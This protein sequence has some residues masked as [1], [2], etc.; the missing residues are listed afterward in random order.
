MSG[1]ELI[2]HNTQKSMK[3]TK[4]LLVVSTLGFA[5]P[6][7]QAELSGSIALDY[8]SHF[9]SYGADVWG[10][11][12]D[13]DDA[14]FNPSLALEYAYSDSIT[15][16]G[17][18]WFDIN[19][20]PGGGFQVQETDFWL[21]LTYGF[22]W[23]SFDVTWQNWQYAGTSEEILDFTLS[24]DTILSPSLTLH[25]RIGEGASGGDEGA[26][27]V[28]SIGYD[29][30]L[31]SGL[32]LGTSASVAAVLSEDMYGGGDDGFAYASLGLS[33]SYATSDVSSIYIGATYYMTEDDVYANP[34]DD[35]LTL[36]AGT[37]FS[38]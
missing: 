20:E 18:V 2:I 34:D 29:F 31:G 22:D 10:G 11:G 15:I 23:G 21:G 25:N 7:A 33:L 36:N 6:F 19:D 5:N 30:D 28:G 26:V 24:F 12:N 13:L 3:T 38:F 8:N 14:L 35:F 1:A 17:G 16:H 37:S 4:V 32:S 9:I 27:L